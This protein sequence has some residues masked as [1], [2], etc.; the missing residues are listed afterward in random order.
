MKTF[1]FKQKQKAENE[2]KHSSGIP[3]LHK[4]LSMIT[5]KK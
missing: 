5:L 3:A 1:I 4:W 2:S